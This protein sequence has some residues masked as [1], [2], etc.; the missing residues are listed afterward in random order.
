MKIILYA[1]PLLLCGFFLV[2]AGLTGFRFISKA[3][4]AG[5]A[6]SPFTGRKVGRSAL[7]SGLYM[8]LAWASLAILGLVPNTGA[9]SLTIIGCSLPMSP[10][11]GLSVTI[12]TYLKAK[13]TFELARKL[14]QRK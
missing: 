5:R 8:A 13:R 2:M 3:E 9:D 6:G 1:F 7:I 12:G 11:M 14:S 4:E 10:I